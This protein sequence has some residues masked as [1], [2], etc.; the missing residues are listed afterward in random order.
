[1]N[2]KMANK[3]RQASVWTDL[4]FL[5]GRI[6]E[7]DR[8]YEP[9]VKILLSV[10][11]PYSWCVHSSQDVLLSCIRRQSNITWDCQPVINFEGLPAEK[12][13]QIQFHLLST[14]NKLSRCVPLL[15]FHER[16]HR[17]NCRTVLFESGVI[18]RFTFERAPKYYLSIGCTSWNRSLLRILDIPRRNFLNYADQML[19]LLKSQHRLHVFRPLTYLIFPLFLKRI[20]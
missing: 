2:L 1:M 18:R 15:S 7:T 3:Q 17:F 13:E 4:F 10:I 20:L 14:I 11:S 9:F 5:M 16:H 19:C 8:N 6:S 12:T